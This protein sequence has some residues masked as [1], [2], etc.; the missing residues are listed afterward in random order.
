MSTI[1]DNTNPILNNV[2]GT[3]FEVPRITLPEASD[4][5][6]VSTS[7]IN[8][9]INAQDLAVTKKLLTANLSF[10]VKLLNNFNNKKEEIQSRLIPFIVKQL[11]PFGPTALQ[12]ITANPELF[13]PGVDLQK[14]APL[15]N[16]LKEYVSCPSQ[17]T[18]LQL[19]NKRN[20]TATQINNLYQNV[21]TISKITNTT[22][23]V[24]NAVQIGITVIQAIPYPSPS[25]G[26]TEIIGEVAD[27]LQTKLKSGKVIVNGLSITSASFGL[28]LGSALNLLNILDLLIQQ[29]SEK[30]DIPFTTIN[31]E[32]NLLNNQSQ[33]IEET[34]QNLIYKGFKLELQLDKTNQTQYAKR[35]AQALSTQGVPVLRTESSFASNPQVLL[36]QLKFI[37]DSNPNLTAE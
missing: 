21:K 1:S 8:Q 7:Q 22:S 13:K 23:I 9:S 24:L 30:Q 33:Q 36:D 10:D 26:L 32:I 3:T 5:T 20:N 15:L 35:Y 27:L 11:S 37:I 29:C 6:N 25:I 4:I 19:I 31:N 18:I 16:E 34:Q 14:M 12:F 28:L 17:P 2:G